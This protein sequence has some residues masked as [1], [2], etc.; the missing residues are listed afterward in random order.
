MTSE[1]GMLRYLE[2]AFTF[3][4]SSI[5]LNTHTKTIHVAGLQRWRLPAPRTHSHQ[6][7]EWKCCDVKFYGMRF[8]YTDMDRCSMILLHNIANFFSE[9]NRNPTYGMSFFKFTFWSAFYL[10]SVLYEILYFVLSCYVCKLHSIL[11]GF[12]IPSTLIIGFL[13]KKM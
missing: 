2:D 9:Y 7:D 13:A 5:V 6:N 8:R 3:H 10:I 4:Y 11:C 1:V 12:K